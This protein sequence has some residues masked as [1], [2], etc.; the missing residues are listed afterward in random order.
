MAE[1]LTLKWGTLKGW[2]IESDAPFAIL[3][4]YASHGRSMSVMAQRDTPAQKELLCQLIDR[5]DGPIFND[6]EGREMTKDEAKE[7]VRN[8]GTPSMKGDG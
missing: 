3:K 6:W 1:S 7:Y 4:E 5:I 8:Y 2:D